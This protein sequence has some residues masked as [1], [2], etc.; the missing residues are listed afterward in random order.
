RVVERQITDVLEEQLA[1]I[2]GLEEMTSTSVD[3]QAEINMEFSLD[4]DVDDA[5]NDVRTRLGRIR[6]DL[7]DGAEAPSIRTADSSAEEVMSLTL[8]SDRLNPLQITD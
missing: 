7:P 1:G 5:A 8:T 4:T 3:E 2:P 6:D